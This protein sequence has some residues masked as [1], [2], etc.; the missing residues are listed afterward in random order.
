MFAAKN[1]ALRSCTIWNSENKDTNIKM[2]DNTQFLSRKN[3]VVEAAPRITRMGIKDKIENG[4]YIETRIHKDASMKIFR[5]PAPVKVHH[6]FFVHNLQ[7]IPNSEKKIF[8]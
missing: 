5:H 6:S 8:L 4:E 7:N 3:R 2:Q 1:I